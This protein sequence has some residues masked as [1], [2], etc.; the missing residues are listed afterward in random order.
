M[1]IAVAGGTGLVGGYV[2]AEAE[3][4][5]HRCIPLSRARGIDITTGVGL[6][7]SLE[8]VDVVVDVTNQSLMSGAKARKFFTLVTKNLIEAEKAAGVRHHVALS[9]AGIDG[10]DF[11]YYSGKLAQ[12]RTIEQSGFPHTIVRAAQFHEFAGQQMKS[13]PGP[14]ALLPKFLMRP[15]AAREV[16]N[17]IVDL[18]EGEPLSRA[19][20]IV[21]PRD[22]VLANLARRQIAFEKSR[23]FVVEF[24]LP[25]GF[26]KALTSGDLRGEA[27]SKVSSLTFDDWLGTSNHKK[28]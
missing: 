12:E 4:R 6:A 25:G 20:D 27:G 14:M 11:G 13:I 1:K 17:Y 5:G 10:H 23:K 15:V 22:E 3:S 18:A 9:I 2:I 28:L 19:A 7:K 21:G 8:G 16:A 26:G 24:T